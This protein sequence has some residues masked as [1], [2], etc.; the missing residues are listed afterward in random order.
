MSTAAK[1]ERG[2]LSHEMSSDCQ[3]WRA[4]GLPCMCEM[5]NRLYPDRRVHVP[6]PLSDSEPDADGG[7]LWM[8]RNALLKENPSALPDPKRRLGVGRY[9]TAYAS[10]TDDWSVVKLQ[11]LAS[12]AQVRRVAREERA[13]RL[14][15]EN[16]VGPAVRAWFTLRG[17]DQMPDRDPAHADAGWLSV[18]GCKDRNVLGVAVAV[19]ERF[20]ESVADA[21]IKDDPQYL[22]ALVGLKARV[23]AM[24]EKTGLYNDEPYQPRNVLVEWKRPECREIERFTVGDWGSFSE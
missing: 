22:R 5:V 6:W 9:W 12:Q 13:Y 20:D 19:V 14:A 16:G 8:V 21:G 17:K 11:P 3:Y 2:V 10:E 1:K 7:V 4:R 24:E 18:K 23:S 15:A